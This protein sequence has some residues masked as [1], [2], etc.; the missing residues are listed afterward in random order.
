MIICGQSRNIALKDLLHHS[1]GPLPWSLATVDGLPR[2]SNKTT[3][4]S[5]LQR[6]VQLAD[7]P[8]SN[9]ATIIDAMS[10]VQKLK[11]GSIKTTFGSVASSLMSMIL[12]EG[13]QS[14]RIDVVF[15][16]Y[17]ENSIKNIERSIRG[18]SPG[19]QVMNITRLANNQAVEVFLWARQRIRPPWY[20]S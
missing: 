6:N 1:R 18:E 12:L 20:I 3:L 13:S 8:P 11:V 16:T 15:D 19:E 5:H 10:L 14:K 7:R 17:R 2:K 9:S 4:A